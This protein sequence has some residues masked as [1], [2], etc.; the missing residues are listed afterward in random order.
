MKLSDNDIELLEKYTKVIQNKM[1]DVI[2]KYI[3]DDTYSDDRPKKRRYL[4]DIE[5]RIRFAI[6][7]TMRF[8][9]DNNVKM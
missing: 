6:D 4:T 3:C 7:D 8:I 2:T 1:S 9:I 5:L